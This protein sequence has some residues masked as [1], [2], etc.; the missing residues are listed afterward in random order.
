MNFLLMNLGQR[1]GGRPIPR[2]ES[3]L[4]TT[5]AAWAIACILVRW[6]VVERERVN[7]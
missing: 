3:L 1:K 2:G 4:T 7:Q 5:K 6:E